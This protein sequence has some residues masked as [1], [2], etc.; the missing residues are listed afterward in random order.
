MIGLLL[1]L[2]ACVCVCAR[3]ACPRRTHEIRPSLSASMRSNNLTMRSGVLPISV[4]TESENCTL[5]HAKQ[6]SSESEGDGDVPLDSPLVRVQAHLLTRSRMP[7]LLSVEAHVGRRRK[8]LAKLL[9]PSRRFHACP[10]AVGDGT[11]PCQAV[12][13]TRRVLKIG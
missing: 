9:P 8:N 12:P 13:L 11:W 10:C 3:V 5:Q 2:H 4:P 1:L 6:Q 7:D